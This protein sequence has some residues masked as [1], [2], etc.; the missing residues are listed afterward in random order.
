MLLY[1]VICIVLWSSCQF[2]MAKVVASRTSIKAHARA[3]N[4]KA[5][6]P[7]RQYSCAWSTMTSH[8][9]CLDSIRDGWRWLDE[10][11]GIIII[12]QATDLVCSSSIASFKLIFITQDQHWCVT[13]RHASIG[14]HSLKIWDGL[15]TDGDYG[16]SV[17]TALY[18]L[19]SSSE[20]VRAQYQL[21]YLL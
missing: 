5:R 7:S 9:L 17:N 1:Y 18:L 6:L 19:D 8:L 10:S 21:A 11:L 15:V 16:S 14:E 4:V 20:I 3:L 12:S 2:Q 13:R